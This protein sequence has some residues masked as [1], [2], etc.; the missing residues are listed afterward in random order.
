MIRFKELGVWGRLR[1]VQA[2]GLADHITTSGYIAFDRSMRENGINPLFGVELQVS[3]L[4]PSKSRSHLTLFALEEE[5]IVSI[6]SLVSRMY[7]QESLAVS[8]DDIFRSGYG[9]AVLSGCLK[10]VFAD[11]IL[12]SIDWSS[13]PPRSSVNS[14]QEYCSLVFHY[15]REI[16]RQYLDKW[17]KVKDWEPFFSALYRTCRTF[18]ARFAPHF[19]LELMP[20]SLPRQIVVNYV[21]TRVSVDLGIPVVM[22]L[23]S[24]YLY[25]QDAV[26]HEVLLAIQSNRKWDDP[27]RFRFSSDDFY[28]PPLDQVADI[29]A[30]YNPFIANNPQLSGKIEEAIRNSNQLGKVQVK[31]PKRKQI[32]TI[33]KFADKYPGLG[34][35]EILRRLVFER[36]EQIGKANDPIYL[37]RLEH[38]LN[39]IH[40]KG[41]E[42]YLLIAREIVMI[43]D[44]LGILRGPGRGSSAGSLVCYLLQITTVDP[45]QFGLMF[46]RFIDITR[47]DFPDIDCDFQDD[48]RDE[49]FEAL[50]ERYGEERVAKI[51]AYVRLG[52][53]STFRRV[54]SVAGIPNSDVNRVMRILPSSTDSSLSAFSNSQELERFLDWY[55]DSVPF[56]IMEVALRLDGLIYAKSVHAAGLVIGDRPLYELCSVER[57]KE[58]DKSLADRVV[59]YDKDDLTEVGLIKYDILGVRFLSVLAK[60]C[61]LLGKS[62]NFL[63][64]IPIDDP[65]VYRM[66]SE[67]EVDC[68]FQLGTSRMRSL[69]LDIQPD[70]FED[71]VALNALIRPGVSRS[72]VVERYAARKHGREKAVPPVD[73]KI[74]HDILKES[75]GL[76]IFQEHIIRILR[77]VAGLEWSVVNKLRKAMAKLQRDDSFQEAEQQFID[78]A[79]KTQGISVEEARRI[80]ETISYAGS[81]AFNKSHSTCYSLISYW[82]AWLKYHYPLEYMLAYMIVNS[83]QPA[84]LQEAII[85]A[86]RL[87]I[88]VVAPMANYSEIGFSIKDGQIYCGLSSI[89]G[90]SSDTAAVVLVLRD[91]SR[92]SEFPKLMDS[93]R[94]GSHK[95]GPFKGLSDFVDRLNRSGLRRFCNIS[96]IR[97]LVM[98]HAFSDCESYEESWVAM[99]QS[100]DR[101]SVRKGTDDSFTQLTLI[102]VPLTVSDYGEDYI[103]PIRAFNALVPYRVGPDIMTV[104]ENFLRSNYDGVFQ[105]EDKGVIYKCGDGYWK[106]NIVF[107]RVIGYEASRRN[108]EEVFQPDTLFLDD[109]IGRV[110]AFT[111][112]RSYIEGW[113]LDWI[114]AVLDV[115]NWEE[116]GACAVIYSS[117]RGHEEMLGIVPLLHWRDAVENEAELSEWEKALSVHPLRMVD[118]QLL[119]DP[120]RYTGWLCRVEERS[121][122][123]SSGYGVIYLHGLQGLVQIAIFSDVWQK[124]RSKF[125]DRCYK[126]VVSLPV[127]SGRF[128]YTFRGSVNQIR[129]MGFKFDPSLKVE[130][131][132]KI[133]NCIDPMIGVF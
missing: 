111:F 74:L 50:V 110:R 98:A 42:G 66:I 39:I 30:H 53:K 19:Y 24:H 43:A 77:E 25:P 79:T 83:E 6:Q 7:S 21:L 91:P 131:Q 22:S 123:G 69:C 72:G 105:V 106:K 40:S 36:L 75:F 9:V 130:Y 70:S 61:Q 44:E 26:V 16:V 38:E 112:K 129:F 58:A 86:K 64:S 133:V 108:E 101:K 27:K 37:A 118:P 115:K 29:F 46:E 90:I 121:K 126:S 127:S 80:Y 18:Q 62:Y 94:A 17:S 84:K 99:K 12:S 20:N 49:I 102:E 65:E 31:L 10:G 92:I 78:G 120:Q 35:D 47:D 117:E 8:F 113:R 109:R 23:D 63:Y 89:K 96:H 124:V 85:E 60:T 67:G 71:L 119:R 128:G 57:M 15:E 5:G 82:T 32:A 116:D 11:M 88:S 48:R 93:Y 114:N 104:Y 59:A 68:C 33:P 54:C 1:G 55:K 34:L 51:M 73:L 52:G 107:G 13:I 3:Q 132:P 97:A 125:F 122:T 56:S 95:V 45:I 87:N 14:A 81:Y 2:V 76:V 41:F 103:E 100:E 28:I 4:N